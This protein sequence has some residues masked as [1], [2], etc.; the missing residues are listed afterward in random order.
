MSA[1]MTILWPDAIPAPASR[2]W[3]FTVKAVTTVS[4]ASPITGSQQTSLRYRRWVARA[5]WP[6]LV[7]D[8]AI[9]AEA[10]LDEM[11]GRAGR[12]MMPVWHRLVTAYPQA[13]RWS[14]AGRLGARDVTITST[15]EWPAGHVIRGGHFVSFTMDNGRHVLHRIAS[16]FRI[17]NQG[18]PATVRLSAPLRGDCT[19]VSAELARPV[20]RMRLV[21]DESLQL[22]HFDGGAAS[23][24]M[25]LV[26][27]PN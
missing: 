4:P 20:C 13:A 21:D 2:G 23:M 12:L 3:Q 7:G 9:A 15:A 6:L 14:L 26:E 10:L 18:A 1:S 27:E 22:R 17:S 25:Q 11:N 24:S 16:D 8:E 19:N 5:E